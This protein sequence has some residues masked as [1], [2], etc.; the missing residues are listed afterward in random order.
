MFVP[1]VGWRTICVSPVH[2]LD[3]VSIGQLADVARNG[4]NF[5]NNRTSSV[6]AF[7]CI[8]SNII[9]LRFFTRP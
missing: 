5:N 9:M 3:Y 8:S 1:P 2:A 6:I 4:Y 7:K